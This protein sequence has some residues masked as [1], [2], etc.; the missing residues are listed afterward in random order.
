MRNPFGV[1]THQYLAPCSRMIAAAVACSVVVSAQVQEP[2]GREAWV[3]F[4]AFADDQPVLDLAS[5][6]V[7]VLVDGLPVQIRSLEVVGSSTSRLLIIVDEDHMPRLERF[8]E[9]SVEAL[10][11]GLADDERVAFASTRPDTQRATRF[12]PGSG[13]PILGAFGARRANPAAARGGCCR[14]ARSS[15]SVGRSTRV[16]PHGRR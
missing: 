5:E 15:T 1:L 9:R 8:M 3:V 4:R 7:T 6:E 2:A 10:L 11:S 13:V 12:C 14:V 16:A